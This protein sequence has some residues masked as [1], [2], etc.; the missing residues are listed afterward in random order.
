VPKHL[1]FIADGERR[2]AKANGLE[3]W[4]GHELGF[5]I[6]F[7]TLATT[8]WDQGVHTFTAWLGSPASIEKR[9]ENQ[10]RHLWRLSEESMERCTELCEK[11][12]ARFCYFGNRSRVPQS[13]LQKINLLENATE[14]KGGEAEGR[15]L[16]LGFDYGGIQDI[17]QA[18]QKVIQ[19]KEAISAKT[20]SDNF[21]LNRT[22]QPYPMPDLIVRPGLKG[23]NTCRLS[24]FM[25]WQ[26]TDAKFLFPR[27][28]G[29][30]LTAEDVVEWIR[31]Y[32]RSERRFED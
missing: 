24:N 8:A 12:D 25:L 21:Y 15:C 29:P 22:N 2:W 20:I 14:D 17:V 7:N 16:N 32:S 19:K 31:E 27:K 13:F 30:E 3:P 10:V 5:K 18:V 6:I 11:Y 1:A 4:Q 26:A 9:P 28:Y 23:Q